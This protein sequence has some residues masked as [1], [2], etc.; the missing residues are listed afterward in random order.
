MTD[1]RLPSVMSAAPL[2]SIN[3]LTVAFDDFVAVSGVSFD[4]HEGQTLAVVGES[5]SG[6]SVTALSI[7]RLVELGTRAKITRGEILFRTPGGQ[8]IDLVTE[9]EPSMRQIRGNQISMIFQEP[10]TSLNP[11]YTVGNQVA[12]AV[13]LHQ[14]VGKA[15][16]QARALEMFELVR[17]PEAKRRLKEYPHQMSGGMRQRVMIAMALSCDPTVLI[18][19]EPTT[20][21]DV[22]IQAQILALMRDLQSE[23]NA[24]V[25]IITH[26]MGV[27]AEVAD[28]VVVMN[29]SKVVEQ[30]SVY[31]VF[32]KPAEP[33]TKALLASVP[34]LG[35]MAGTTEPSRF[36]LVGEQ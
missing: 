9:P 5:G 21:L 32:E 22:T 25:I 6:K 12:E 18:A 33:Y 13:M 11:V 30:G 34:Q 14:D 27:V 17:I 26:D 35:S 36:D 20:A 10:L 19:D 4:V 23:T 15:E 3:D 1:Y 8:T 31:D 24:A 7:M 2:L 29:R 28:D 16:A